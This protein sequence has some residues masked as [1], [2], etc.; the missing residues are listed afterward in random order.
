ME[1]MKNEIIYKKINDD[2]TIFNSNHC[3]TWA[4]HEMIQRI[5]VESHPLQ[6][7]MSRTKF[8]SICKSNK[9]RRTYF[10]VATIRFLNEGPGNRWH[11]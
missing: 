7:T 10:S 11:I 6:Q 3:K 8:S 9:F 5:F 2:V 4:K 1:Q